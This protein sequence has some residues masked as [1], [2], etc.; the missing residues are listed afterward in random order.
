[1]PPVVLV[2]WQILHQVDYRLAQPHK[3]SWKFKHEV[4]EIE[5]IV[6]KNQGI[7]V[8]LEGFIFSCLQM[9]QQTCLGTQR[10]LVVFLPTTEA[11]TE[12]V[13]ILKYMFA[14]RLNTYREQVDI[15]GMRYFRAARNA[16]DA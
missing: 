7:S 15:T 9:L 8:Q 11:H 10:A 2:W 13:M 1:M 6:R 3:F 14:N 5:I 16:L 4:E 12:A